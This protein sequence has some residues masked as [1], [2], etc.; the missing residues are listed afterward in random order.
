MIVHEILG[1]AALEQEESIRFW[2]KG[3]GKDLYIASS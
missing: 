3:K 2:G 1:G